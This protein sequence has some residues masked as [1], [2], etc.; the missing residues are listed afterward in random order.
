[1]G[2]KIQCQRFSLSITWCNGEIKQTEEFLISVYRVAK[3]YLAI[4]SKWG[5]FG[6]K[7]QVKEVEDMF[8]AEVIT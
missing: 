3:I 8:K 5:V 7:K 6:S 4:K 2:E 1:M